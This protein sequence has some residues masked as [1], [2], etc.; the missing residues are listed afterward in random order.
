VHQD[1]RGGEGQGLALQLHAAFEDETR[2]GEAAV[3]VQVSVVDR[4][5]AFVALTLQFHYIDDVL[6]YRNLML[7]T[8]GKHPPAFWSQFNASN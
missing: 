7:H 8:F 2:G 6:H 3:E 1:G 5:D 4:G